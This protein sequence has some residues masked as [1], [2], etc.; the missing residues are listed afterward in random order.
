[1]ET[2]KKKK[3]ITTQVQYYWQIISLARV[4]KVEVNAT[5]ETV[6]ESFR[7]MQPKR[8]LDKQPPMPYIQV[9]QVEDAIHTFSFGDLGG[10]QTSG[11]IVY[12]EGYERAIIIGQHRL[13][14][15][16]LALFGVYVFMLVFGLGNMSADLLAESWV[17]DLLFFLAVLTVYLSSLSSTYRAAKEDLFVAL[18]GIPLRDDDPLDEEDAFIIDPGQVGASGQSIEIDA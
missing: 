10:W 18:D 8:P 16:Q 13:S 6:A 11:R 4:F 3:Q 1:M 17:F 7:T 5:G 15:L 12:S 14:P 2:M 9:S